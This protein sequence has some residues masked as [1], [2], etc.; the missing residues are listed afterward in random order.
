MSSSIAIPKRKGAASRPSEPPRSES[1]YGS[2]GSVKAEGVASSPSSK[3][4]IRR[5]SLMCTSSC[6]NHYDPPMPPHPPRSAARMKRTAPPQRA[7]LQCVNADTT[8]LQRRPSAKSSTPSSTWATRTAPDWYD[9]PV[10]HLTPPASPIDTA[11]AESGLRHECMDAADQRRYLVSRR[12]RALI[13]IKVR[14]TRAYFCHIVGD[15]AHR[16]V[17]QRQRGR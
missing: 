3:S 13:G 14:L 15:D 4:G 1:E 12:L 2:Y 8:G 7:C 11:S 17:V 5:P 9:G 6:L 16:G 10:H